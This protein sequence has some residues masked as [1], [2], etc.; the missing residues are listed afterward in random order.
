MIFDTERTMNADVGRGPGVLMLAGIVTFL[1]VVFSPTVLID[2]FNADDAAAQ[3][4]VIEGAR[5]EWTVVWLVL[6]AATL[7]LGFGLWKL[8]S[9][10]RVQAGDDQTR[11]IA[12]GAGILALV[13]QA[14]YAAVGI[15]GIVVSPARAVEGPAGGSPLLLWSYVFVLLLALSGFAYV[16]LRLRLRR[17]MSILLAVIVV[18]HLLQLVLTGDIVPL[19]IYLLLMPIAIA[20][21][22]RPLGQQRLAV[23]AAPA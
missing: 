4:A 10:L 5:L 14:G 20:L 11:S 19:S 1:V 15:Y 3:A 8:A 17:W 22:V 9:A 6:A 18:L 23:A 21:I 13:G 16:L 2:F 7:L 12:R